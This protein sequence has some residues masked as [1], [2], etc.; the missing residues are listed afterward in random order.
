MSVSIHRNVSKHQSLR[1][2]HLAKNTPHRIFRSIRTSH[3]NPHPA[4][5]PRIHLAHWSRKSTRTP[6]LPQHLCIRPRPP[7]I[8]PRSVHPP[9]QLHRPVRLRNPAHVFA[10]PLQRLHSTLIRAVGLHHKIQRLGR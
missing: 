3:H 2:N 9:H 8:F 7:H 5:R 10:Q 4:A 1:R 6:P